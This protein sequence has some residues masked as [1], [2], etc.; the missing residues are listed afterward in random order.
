MKNDRDADGNKRLDTKNPDKSLRMVPCDEVV[1][2]TGLK[3]NARKQCWDGTKIYD[4][5]RGF[6]AKMSA[7]F[8]DDAT[9][10][11]TGTVLGLSGHFT[12]KK[13]E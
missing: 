9:L 5:Q 1:L 10:R 3:H 8:I 11:I 7:A 6:S 13:L 4:L 2:F 12:W